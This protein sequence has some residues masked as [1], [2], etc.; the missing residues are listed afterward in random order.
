MSRI[1][2]VKHPEDERVRAIF[3]EIEDELGAVPSLFRVFA[4]LPPL[5][6]ANWDKF[7]AIF[8]HGCLSAQLKEAIGL[9]V[10]AEANCDYGIYHHSANLEDLG[11][12]PEEVMRIRTDPENVH[13]SDKERA[14]FDLAR[15]AATDPFDHGPRLIEEAQQLGARDDEIVEALGV[16]DMAVGFNHFSEILALEPHRDR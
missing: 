11:V 6:E 8:V 14:L 13:F 2:L 7:K 10:C 12:D 16:M 4:H 5:L 3:A 9:V 1:S 15:H